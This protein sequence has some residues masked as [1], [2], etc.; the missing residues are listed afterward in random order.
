M[1]NLQAQIEDA[2]LEYADLISKL[3]NCHAKIEQLEILA[4]VTKDIQILKV[5]HV[6]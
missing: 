5:E 4:E 1:T 2:K 6:A 3:D